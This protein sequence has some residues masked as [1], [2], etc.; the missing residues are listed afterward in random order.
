MSKVS[1]R[2]LLLLATLTILMI[3]A[4][5]NFQR[6]MLYYP[7]TSLP[8]HADLAAA[9]I[10]SWPSESNYRG[11]TGTSKL[12]N[13]KGTI[14]VFHGNAGTAAD[15]AHYAQRLGALGYRV[16][17]AEYPGYGARQGTPSEKTFV[18]DAQDTLRLVS[19]QF[20]GPYYL[21]GESLGCGVVGS[22]IKSGTIKI[23]GIV[24]LTP[25]D[26]LAALAKRMF[27][28]L[29]IKL[30]LRDKYDSIDNLRAYQGKIA[31]VAAER[32]EIIP[33]THAQEL[34]KSLSTNPA[35]HKMYV[36]KDASHND[37]PYRVDEAWWKGVMG[38]INDSKF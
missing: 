21:F 37:W 29:P 13:A 9:Q 36:I 28:W 12:T 23:D 5:C 6:K 38:F 10:Q 20:A 4:S 34:F 15:R 25:W 7:D 35:L 18:Q 30:F 14:I 26:S 11:F 27:P 32:D 3:F 8:S 33:I 22:V 2:L 1:I 19:E 24:L 31:I 17:L 16:V